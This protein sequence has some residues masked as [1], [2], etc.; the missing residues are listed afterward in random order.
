M[1]GMTV[2]RKKLVA[3]LVLAFTLAMPL[4]VAWASSY[5]TTLHF[6][7]YLNGTTRSYDGSN[8]ACY[9]RGATSSAQ[10]LFHARPSK[11]I[12]GIPVS[13]GAWKDYP[14]IGSKTNSWSGIGKGSYSFE[15]LK[16]DDGRYVDSSY[17]KMYNY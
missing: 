8:L 11:Y 16:E 15:F 3:S 12:L 1:T 5:T 14:R 4:A 7:Y 2:S 10:G 9:I 6:K 17:V 13:S